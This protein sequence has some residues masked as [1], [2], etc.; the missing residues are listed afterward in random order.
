MT[1]AGG[2]RLVV[3]VDYSH[4]DQSSNVLTWWDYRVSFKAG[5]TAKPYVDIEFPGYE[6][7]LYDVL[8]ATSPAVTHVDLGN[9]IHRFEIQEAG[10][11]GNLVLELNSQYSQER[12]VRS[13]VNG[14]GQKDNFVLP[15][16]TSGLAHDG[17]NSWAVVFGPMGP[18]THMDYGD[19]PD[20]YRT[21][22]ASDGPRY[23][24]SALQH[25]G[26]RWDYEP[27]GQP[28]A[29]ADGD[30]LNLWGYGGPDDEDG[31]IFGSSWVDLFVEILRP[32][33]NEY[34]LRAWWDMNENGM[35]DHLAELLIDDLLSLDVGGYW[36]HYDLGFDPLAYYS[37]FR[38][39]W[40]DDPLGLVGGVS[41]FTDITPFGEF[42][43]ADGISHGEVEDYVPEP[44]TYLLFGIG[45]L[46]IFFGLHL[47]GRKVPRRR[48]AFGYALR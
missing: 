35:F 32:G 48:T 27:D 38:L 34:R 37:R 47:G 23:Q 26:R 2:A 22:L 7:Y 1:L 28:T 19:A 3:D 42:L 45:T 40:L 14:G 9:D 17:N 30:D 12:R 41:L 20:S 25:L 15:I 36:L 5:G 6:G 43:S 13:W 4:G 21:L 33:Q 29:R 18:E 16:N 11:V 46:A 44:P 24:E 39:T 8:G 10:W 31:V